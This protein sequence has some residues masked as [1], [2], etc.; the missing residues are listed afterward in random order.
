MKHRLTK[1]LGLLHSREL[2]QVT[3][4][5]LMEGDLQVPVALV[6]N[7]LTAQAITRSCD[8]S[9]TNAMISSKLQGF[10]MHQSG[11]LPHHCKAKLQRLHGKGTLSRVL[12]G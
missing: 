3:L 10:G 12:W 4:I 6:D 1:L 11:A 2:R 8:G 5:P 9:L 7:S